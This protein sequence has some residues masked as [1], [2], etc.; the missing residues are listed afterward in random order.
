MSS[1]KP[2]LQL[3]KDTNEKDNPI[4]YTKTHRITK[5]LITPSCS[6]E[7][8][9]IHQRYKRL[10]NLFHLRANVQRIEEGQRI[11]EV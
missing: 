10:G 1:T 9:K 8:P 2:I 6:K 4:F 7:D 5:V 3:I 11:V